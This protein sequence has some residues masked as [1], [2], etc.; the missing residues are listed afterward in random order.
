MNLFHLSSYL[1]LQIDNKG[2]EYTPKK[3]AA[4]TMP[5]CNVISRGALLA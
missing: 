4:K 5:D 1:F 3:A 2:S